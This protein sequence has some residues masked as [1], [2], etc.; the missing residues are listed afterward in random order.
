MGLLTLPCAGPLL[1]STFPFHLLHFMVMPF[2]C[3]DMRYLITYAS[4]PG[5]LALENSGMRNGFFTSALLQHIRASSHDTDVQRLLRAVRDTVQKATNGRQ[6]PFGGL[7]NLG[8]ADVFLVPPPLDREVPVR[9][10]LIDRAV[11]AVAFR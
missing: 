10:P 6:T 11:C 9:R 2:V 3:R 8:G 7:E 1:H 5:T 4:A